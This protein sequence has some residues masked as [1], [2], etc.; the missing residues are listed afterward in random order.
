MGRPKSTN[1]KS[2][3]FGVSVD[4]GTEIALRDYCEKHGISKGEAVR[5]AIKMLLSSAN[6]NK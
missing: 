4:I 3:E 2:V 1:P 6:E 5:R